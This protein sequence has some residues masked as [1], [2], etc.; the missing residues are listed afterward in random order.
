MKCTL[1]K[2]G[3]KWYVTYNEKQN[4]GTY[5]KIWIATGET[6][7]TKAD[8]KLTEIQHQLNN[9]T[10]TKKEKMTLKEILDMWM[11][12]HVE[13]NLEKSTYNGYKTIIDKYMYPYFNDI[14]IQKVTTMEIEKYYKHLQEKCISKKNK[15]GLSAN[16]VHRHHVILSAVF[17]YAKTNRLIAFNV[18]EVVTLPRKQ[19]YKAKIY[20]DEEVKILI[21]KIEGTKIEIL[22]H[23]AVGLGLRLSEICGLTWEKIDFERSY[24]Y[25]DRARVRDTKGT[26]DKDTKNESSTRNIKI[27]NVLLIILDNFKKR[28]EEMYS[29]MGQELNN[30]DYVITKD[31]G[32]VLHPSTLSHMF[33]DFLLINEL[34]KIRLH[35]L[36]HTNISLLL[37][38]KV[39][40]KV[41]QRRGGWSNMK[42]MFD[43]YAHILE[44]M[45]EE[46]DTKIENAIYK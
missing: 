9:G 24:I 8:P 37:R 44:E 23:L 31:D 12:I 36:R 10:F 38:N 1:I 27:P 43:T 28:K 7:K 29:K 33:S 5:K 18:C 3:D 14:E 4:N 16:T 6:K 35:D 2:K 13:T 45:E 41:V 20:T 46:A 32:K 11:S 26:M 30:T 34:K 15:K 22:T 21:D 39:D 40:L 42:T 25:I 19:K 17:K